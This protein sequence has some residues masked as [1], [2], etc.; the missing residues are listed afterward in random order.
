MDKTKFSDLFDLDVQKGLQQLLTYMQKL[1][2]EQAKL[3]RATL[4]GP[5][6]STVAGFKKQEKAFSD[7]NALV[8]ESERLKKTQITLN[9]KLATQRTKEAQDLAKTR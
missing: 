2:K 8:K 5:Q 7:M 4:Q 6:A 9:A 1:V 3:N